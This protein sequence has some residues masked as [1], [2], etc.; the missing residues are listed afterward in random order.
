MTRYLVLGLLAA[1]LVVGLGYV[2]YSRTLGAAPPEPV[3]TAPDT[4]PAARPVAPP[5]V[6]AQRTRVTAVTGK[7][8]RRA[9]SGWATL[10]VGDELTAR[11]TIRTG[12]GASATLDAGVVV[13]VADR[14]ELTV[15]EITA[16]L[17]EL[18]LAEGRITANA[19]SGGPTVRISTRNSDAIAQ[20]DTGRFDVLSTGAGDMT[21][22]ARE[23]TV[24]VTGNRKSVDVTAGQ[25]STVIAGRAPTAPS[26]IPPSLFL[27]VAANHNRGV[28]NVRG[29]APP[30][31]VVSINGVRTAVVPG[32]GRFAADVPIEKGETKI[33]VHVEDVLGRTER[34]ILARRIGTPKL[35]TEV[36]WQ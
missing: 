31:A 2:V 1:C 8:E 10:K 9:S 19:G 32:D 25:Q 7:V 3:T 5:P 15:G 17:S 22:A 27:K 6:P 34:K 11:D 21:V 33:I 18:A 20:A 30:G 16:S 35:E 23:G 4:A 29:E 13:E 12:D 28:S 14:T 26:A 24:R 36:E